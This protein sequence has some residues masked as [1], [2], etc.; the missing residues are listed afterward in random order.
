M[1]SF[2]AV[3]STLAAGSVVS[4]LSL[5]V[6]GIAAKN[7]HYGIAPR[8]AARP[9][10]TIY[11]PS[12]TKAPNHGNPFFGW[13]T[14][15]LSLSYETILNGVPGTGTRQNGLAGTLLSANLDAIVFLRFN[16]MYL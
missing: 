13:I 7:R 10:D 12:P 8:C 9:S 4:V 16:G 5:L 15:V 1:A 6:Y 14:W 2:E 11:N 3:A